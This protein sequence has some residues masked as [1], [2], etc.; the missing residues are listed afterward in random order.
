[1]TI[2]VK[3]CPSCL[4]STSFTEPFCV[5]CGVSVMEVEATVEE[6]KEDLSPT[7]QPAAEQKNCPVCGAVNE[8]Y[9]VLCCG[10]NCGADLRGTR[11]QTQVTSTEPDV[12]KRLFLIIGDQRFECRDGDV[13]GREGSIAPEAFA[14]IGTVSRRHVILSCNED[15]WS[16]KIEDG[17]SN[18]T[19]LD[20]HT[21]TKNVAHPLSGEHILKMS[22]HCEV[23]LKVS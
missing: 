15:G 3:T 11:T 13:L 18:P 17:V 8:S 23:R 5:H 14:W 10:P 7:S 20:G 12:Q 16:A 9:A 21:M 22:G 19:Q 1:M 4:Q 2:R 6:P